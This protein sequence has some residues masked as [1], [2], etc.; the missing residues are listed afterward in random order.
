M[1]T[2]THRLFKRIV[3]RTKR[4]IREEIDGDFTQHVVERGV[5]AGFEFDNFHEMMCSVP[6]DARWNGDACAKL[7]H[8]A[9]YLSQEDAEQVVAW[10]DED[11]GFLL[12]EDVDRSPVWDDGGQ[13][14]AA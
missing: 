9:G 12:K 2:L 13:A 1:I 10:L 4:I 7:F 3:S 8:E 6:C 11:L 14:E 5:V